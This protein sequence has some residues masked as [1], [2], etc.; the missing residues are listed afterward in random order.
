MAYATQR[1][2]VLTGESWLYAAKWETVFL[3]ISKT[4]KST[5]GQPTSQWGRK[6]IGIE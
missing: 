5:G 1:T 6:Y 3:P 4:C 2:L